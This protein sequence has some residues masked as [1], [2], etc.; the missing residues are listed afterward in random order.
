MANEN[1]T[2]SSNLPNAAVS[3][4]NT[5][6]SNAAQCNEVFSRSGT[7]DTSCGNNGTTAVVE[8]LAGQTPPGSMDFGAMWRACRNSSF[9]DGSGNTYS[10]KLPAASEWR[11][12]ADWGDLDQDGVIDVSV[13]ATNVG[14]SVPAIEYTAGDPVGSCNSSSTVASVTGTGARAGCQSR[15]GASEMVGSLREWSDDRAYNMV[16]FDNGV[17]G[18]F[19][20]FAYSVSS[21]N[22]FDVLRGMSVSSGAWHMP[23]THVTHGTTSGL[24]ALT[25]G[26]SSGDTVYNGRWYTSMSSVS[27]VDIR[28]GGRCMR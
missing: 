26:G 3:N 15:Y 25:L 28:T 19:L 24:T 18:L 7:F 13:Y 16:G 23:S 11:K 1:P 10:L 20:G 2:G 5:W 6:V 4:S 8:S 12:A 27:G 9:L 14:V 17:D 22:I 21:P